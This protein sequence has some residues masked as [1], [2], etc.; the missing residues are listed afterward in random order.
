MRTR[1]RTPARCAVPEPS[2][3]RRTRIRGA[4][5]L[6]RSRSC[7]LPP[8]ACARACWWQL[9]PRAP[10]SV[11][12]LSDNYA[13]LL[14]DE[15]SGATAVVDT[16]EV[17][18]VVAELE[19]RGWALT[20]VLNT[21]H[22]GDHVGGNAELKAKYGCTVVGPEMDERI[23]GKVTGRRCASHAW[24]CA[25]HAASRPPV[26]AAG[27]RL[28][29]S[30]GKGHPSSLAASARLTGSRPESVGCWRERRRHV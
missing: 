10:T 21:H 20:H 25:S 2:H 29:R 30:T 26:R 14:R 16:P 4:A 1:L 17:A 15:R 13:W 11:P 8:A 9:T 22:H 24:H 18:P 12:C 3:R 7:C 27:C 5:C 19:A 6:G 23:P 28:R